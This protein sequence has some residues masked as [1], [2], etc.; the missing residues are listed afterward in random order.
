MNAWHR[1]GRSIGRR[2]AALAT[3]ILLIGGI[4]S[5]QAS[6]GD[7]D[8]GFSSDGKVLTDIGTADSGR[9]V[10]IQADGKVVVAG[11]ARMGSDDDFAVAR[12]DSDGALDAAF[13]SDGLVTVDFDNKNESGYAVAV[14]S[15]GK[16]VVAG[17]A[18][19]DGMGLT[20]DFAV[21]RLTSS[22]E[23]DTSFSS[24]GLQTVDVGGG[25]D[26]A[27]SVAVASDGDI[28]V[29]GY[30]SNG[31]NWDV[32]AIRLDSS[33]NLD[34]DFSS[35]GKALYAIGSGH[36]YGYGLDIASDGDLLITGS[37]HNGSDDDV[38]VLRLDANGTL[39]T[40]FDGDGIWTA[41]IGSGTSDEGRGI[42]EASD[43]DVLVGGSTDDGDDD[44]L[45]VRL[46]P[47]GVLDT[48]FS[49]DGKAT[50]AIGSGNDVG[51]GVAEQDDGSVV[52]VGTSHDG[53]FED[54]A[55][56][57]FTSA[58]AL[59]TG[60]SGDGK[61]TTDSG[62]GDAFGYG[63]VLTSA[64]KVVVA[65]EA[66]GTS[67]ADFAVLV[68][69]GASAPGAP[70]SL[71][72]TAGDQQVELSWTAPTGNGGVSLTG[73]RVESST[74]SGSSWSTVVAD[75]GS[76][77]TSYTATSLANGTEYLFRVSAINVVG[78][79]SASSSATATPRTTPGQPGSLSAT[80]G[81]AQVD[82]SWSDP[83]SDGGSAVTGYKVEQ[84]TDSGLTWA[85]VVA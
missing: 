5:A 33:G 84:S 47:V 61:L 16:I 51:Y 12:Y 60:F 29:V 14:Q 80:E 32:A 82:L 20:F 50:V 2:V 18:A 48:A 43:G 8:T 56:V 39:D 55:V 83:S 22:G 46:T 28:V 36:D 10:A 42:V 69:E 52:V 62:S 1:A 41:D 24:D 40:A 54:I 63:V 71:G 58:G 17:R 7:L 11:Y 6:P 79:G 74:N 59:D 9:A 53:S 73:Y 13:S 78:A 57:R 70:T 76:T 30:G 27:Y 49:S 44:I 23:L 67:D 65:G 15:D 68:Y 34:T 38:L 72:G 19:T 85:T 81:T 3:L 35:D 77:S 25:N 21:V 37:S 31:S 26:Y 45:A 66:V 4:P 64:G 75:T